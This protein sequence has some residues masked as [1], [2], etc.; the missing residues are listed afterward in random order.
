MSAFIHVLTYVGLPA[1]ILAIGRTAWHVSRARLLERAGDTA[2]EKGSKSS[3]GMAG[4]EIVKAL[5]G[6]SEPWWRAILPWR[7]TGDDEP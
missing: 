2:L 7:R 3:R 5:T 6:E 1:V 4:L